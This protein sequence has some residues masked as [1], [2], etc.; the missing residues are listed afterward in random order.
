M[1]ELDVG[2]AIDLGDPEGG[3]LVEAADDLLHPEIAEHQGL[4]VE[5]RAQEGEEALTVDVDGERLLAD[6]LALDLV[7]AP[8]LT[9]KY[10]RMGP[11]VPC[12]RERSQGLRGIGH[13]RGGPAA[14]SLH[15]DTSSR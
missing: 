1:R 13:R 4:E 2:A 7:Q 3:N 11:M 5:G 12:R 6:D 10:V 14:C 8:T 15:V 9:W